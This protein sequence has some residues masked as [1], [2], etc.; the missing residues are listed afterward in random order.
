VQTQ[1]PIDHAAFLTW[2]TKATHDFYV[3]VMGWPLVVAWGREDGEPPFFITGY[4]A[5]GW[6]IEFEEMA[7]LP[8]ASPAPAPAFPH[9][10]F[11]V[12][13]DD[14]LAAWK[15][16]LDAHAVDYLEEG[17]AVYFTDPNA[18]TF[19]VFRKESHGT[20]DERIAKSTANLAAWL[21]R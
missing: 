7:G 10:G 12:E 19:Q 4:D 5:G 2:D 14:E 6:V 11:V 9:F 13:T 15:Q 3:D 16:R 18:V 20:L 17:G 21:S 1:L 8:H